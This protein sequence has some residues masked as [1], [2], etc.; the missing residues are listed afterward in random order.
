MYKVPFAPW[1]QEHL[2][3]SVLF[4]STMGVYWNL[5]YIPI[6]ANEADLC[7]VLSWPQTPRYKSSALLLLWTRTAR[8]TGTSGNPWADLLHVGCRHRARTLNGQTPVSCQELPSG[9]PS[10]PGVHLPC[11]ANLGPLTLG[12]HPLGA[13]DLDLAQTRAV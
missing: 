13:Q 5:S 2:T 12:A 6:D 11:P 3:F 10:S 9:F 7:H 8:S 1:P 4:I